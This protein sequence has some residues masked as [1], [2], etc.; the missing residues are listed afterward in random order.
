[1]QNKA[2]KGGPIGQNHKRPDCFKL[3][4]PLL[5]DILLLKNLMVRTENGK[6]VPQFHQ[7]KKKTFNESQIYT[8][9][10]LLVIFE[11]LYHLI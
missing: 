5:Q 9:L 6:I 1:M 7:F 4:F 10:S 2:F 11:L 8:N 3:F